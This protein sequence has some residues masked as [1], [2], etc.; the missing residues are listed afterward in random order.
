MYRFTRNPM[1]LGF[2][3]ML[4]GLALFLGNLFSALLPVL[5]AAYLNQFQI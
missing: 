3:H 4:A 5:F 2:L 1:Y